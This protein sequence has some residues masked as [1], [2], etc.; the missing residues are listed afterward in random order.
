VLHRT[1]AVQSQ[2]AHETFTRV[3]HTLAKGVVGT[4]GPSKVRQSV[5]V[6]FDTVEFVGVQVQEVATLIHAP[7]MKAG[8]NHC[9]APKTTKGT[10]LEG[11][12]NPIFA[13]A[14][15]HVPTINCP[16]MLPRR[17]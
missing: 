4:S 12:E 15:N 16:G 14:V 3:E 6:Q 7:D 17:R 10:I 13:D 5:D 1:Q 2:P 8:R 9:E 11:D